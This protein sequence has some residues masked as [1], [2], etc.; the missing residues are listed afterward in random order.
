VRLASLWSRFLTAGFMRMVSV[1]AGMS[2]PIGVQIH[3]TM[4]FD[5]STHAHREG[6]PA[7]RKRARLAARPRAHAGYGRSPAAMEAKPRSRSAI[8]SSTSS[9]PI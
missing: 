2:G 7:Y 6:S 5:A 9:S 3:A 4:P 1:L 8:R